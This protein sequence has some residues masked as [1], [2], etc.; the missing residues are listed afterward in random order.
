VDKILY[1]G[2]IYTGRV[3]NS[4][5]ESNNTTTF[6]QDFIN[7]ITN[8][9]TQVLSV[10]CI[11]IF[12]VVFADTISVAGKKLLKEEYIVQLKTIALHISSG[13][14]NLVASIRAERL[15]DLSEVAGVDNITDILI[16]V[17]KD[18]FPDVRIAAVQLMGQV[19][20]KLPEIDN[21][22][23]AAL[24]DSHSGVRLAAI[25]ALNNR[26]A[27]P[28]EKD[29]VVIQLAFAKGKDDWDFEGFI[30]KDC[31]KLEKQREKA[32]VYANQKSD[33]GILER[34]RIVYRKRAIHELAKIGT[35][36]SKAALNTLKR[37]VDVDIRTAAKNELDN[38]SIPQ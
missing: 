37:D 22:L 19:T 12:S 9:F 3:Y 28:K 20:K 26:K 38:L 32:G 33:P 25:E 2:I 13:N 1:A 30:T 21:A 14:E 17:I 35:A 23:I 18:K 16:A 6:N 36:S 5:T 11:G 10:V 24:K 27:F 29:S 8:Q 7:M 34:T 15:H 4:A 31:I